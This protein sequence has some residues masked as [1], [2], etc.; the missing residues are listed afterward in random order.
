[1]FGDKLDHI[2]SV[3]GPLWIFTLQCCVAGCCL[4]GPGPGVRGL[5]RGPAEGDGG[6]PAAHPH[7]GQEG[8]PEGQ[9]R[10]KDIPGINLSRL[11]W[12]E[13]L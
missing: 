8:G 12:V 3:Q 5:Q 4:E 6:R 11:I 10:H 1:M 13:V 2:L 7:G 9:R